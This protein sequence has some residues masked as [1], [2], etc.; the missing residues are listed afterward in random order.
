MLSELILD[1][2]NTLAPK[3]L[4]LFILLLFFLTKSRAK[5]PLSLF[6]KLE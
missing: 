1:K 3:R 2:N 4:L 6:Q 5:V